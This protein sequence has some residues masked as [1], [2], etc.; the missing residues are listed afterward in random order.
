MR[1]LITS[2]FLLLI[3]CSCSSPQ[4]EDDIPPKEDPVYFKAT[5][6]NYNEQELYSY[7]V[8][9]GETPIY[10]GETPTRE[11]DE[12]YN[13]SFSGWSP[14]LGPIYKDT[15][16]IAQFTQEE[17]NYHQATFKNYDDS[18]LFIDDKLKDGDI[19]TYEGETP[20]RESDEQYHY[21]FVG[22]DK[23]I[24]AIYDDVTYYATYETEEIEQEDPY[25]TIHDLLSFK[26]QN[27]TVTLEDVGVVSVHTP[28]D[29]YVTSIHNPLD[30]YSIRVH[31]LD[32]YINQFAQNDIVTV[33]GIVLESDG[34]AY[35][36]SAHISWGTGG[37]NEC[38]DYA[39]IGT[40][41]IPSREVWEENY[42]YLDDGTL[43]NSHM[44]IASLPDLESSDLSFYVTFPGE[45]YIV[46]DKNIYLIPVIIPALTNDQ[47]EKVK[48]WVLQF[49][50]GD[51]VYLNYQMYF[52]NNIKGMV[53]AFDT[54]I[55]KTYNILCTKT[56]C[57]HSRVYNDYQLI[58][59]FFDDYYDGYACI[60]NMSHEQVFSYT[61][62]ECSE[63]LEDA[64]NKYIDVSFYTYEI[65]EVINTLIN[66][67]SN[68][69]DFTYDGLNSKNQHVINHPYSP[70]YDLQIYIYQG[71]GKVVFEAHLLDA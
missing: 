51:P 2:F 16:Y 42:T 71:F 25:Y 5:F 6:L 39:F 13:Y 7:Q 32:E 22:W 58:Q 60:P 30:R 54:L 41:N 49:E 56:N 1:K 66:I 20:T 53:I 8:L 3:L 38:H 48:E 26:H 34:K 45:D 70:G 61:K 63:Y 18:I 52:E 23:P 43:F 68:H 24:E 47:I 40:I 64:Y 10:Q 36:D 59:T 31:I 37:E 12:I 19:P 67:Y 46:S 29:L 50:I 21:H 28:N 4:K 27:K 69:S 44:N 35:L 15:T 14:I 57:A 65:D 55:S 62:Q 9:E 17:I 33:T 11:S